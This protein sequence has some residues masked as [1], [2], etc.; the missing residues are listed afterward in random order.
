MSKENTDFWVDTWPGRFLLNSVGY[1]LVFCPIIIGLFITKKI[2]KL[3]PTIITESIWERFDQI[4]LGQSALDRPP[5][6]NFRN[7][8]SA[9][10]NQNKKKG[11]IWFYFGKRSEA[12]Q[13]EGE[14]KKEV[15]EDQS[16]LN[17]GQ[18]LLEDELEVDKELGQS[19][20][21]ESNRQKERKKFLLK[22][23]TLFGCASGLWSSLIFYG[24]LQVGL[25]KNQGFADEYVPY[26]MSEVR[27]PN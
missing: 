25:E 10:S 13:T 6:T 21:E 1:I 27:T 11:L 9:E 12:L 16:D 26:I 23:L 14:A 18:S 5:W 20:I 2:L 3:D 22:A 17:S 8:P 19:T 15:E 7:R 4:Y 24:L